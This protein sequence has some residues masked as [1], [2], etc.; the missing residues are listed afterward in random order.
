MQRLAS[1]LQMELS[2]EMNMC[3]L[4]LAM[5]ISELHENSPLIIGWAGTLFEFIMKQHE[6]GMQI[7]A[8]EIINL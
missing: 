4:E 6:T 3:M 5:H 1:S 2:E 7:S 8:F